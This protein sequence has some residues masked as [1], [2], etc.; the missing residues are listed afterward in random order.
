MWE[1]VV[2]INRCP[3]VYEYR[4]EPHKKTQK[5]NNVIWSGKWMFLLYF[6]EITTIKSI[7]H[8]HLYFEHVLG[9]LLK[10]N[11]N[12]HWPHIDI[13]INNDRLLKMGEL[14]M[15]P[16]L[17]RGT[18]TGLIPIVRATDPWLIEKQI[19]VPMFNIS[20]NQYSLYVRRVW[21]IALNRLTFW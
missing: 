3:F 20:T 5:H 15:R 2:A 17:C 14:R 16:K 21:A 1:D 12:H 6:E 19:L 11:L 9:L 8:D 10:Y 18:S 4:F 7:F 13:V